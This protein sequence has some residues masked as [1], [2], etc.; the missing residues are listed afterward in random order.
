MVSMIALT[1]WT[2]VLIG[3]LQRA[4]FSSALADDQTSN[5]INSSNITC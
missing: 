2:K 4:Y 3:S 5:Y 1:V